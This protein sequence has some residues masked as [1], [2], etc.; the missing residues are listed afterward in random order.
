[1]GPRGDWWMTLEHCRY[2]SDW[3]C[4]RF[5]DALHVESVLEA[6]MI[7]RD[8]AVVCEDD[9]CLASP[10]QAAA[11]YPALVTARQMMLGC[12]LE[13]GVVVENDAG[14]L[15]IVGGEVLIEF[16]TDVPSSWM[17]RALESELDQ[18][19]LAAAIEH[20]GARFTLPLLPRSG[21]A[22]LELASRLGRRADVVVAVPR[23]YRACLTGHGTWF[24]GSVQ[25]LKKGEDN[26]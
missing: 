7:D 21:T 3:I 8:S 6:F 18:L 24:D 1:M 26:K 2:V 17:N 5:E 22:A 10:P 25:L 14:E 13:V 23:W 16:R 19:E 12:G 11:S 15:F 9:W 4:S 20:D